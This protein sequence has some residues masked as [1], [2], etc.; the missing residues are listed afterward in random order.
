MKKFVAILCAVTMAFGLVGCEKN[1]KRKQVLLTLW[2]SEESHDLM[3][4]LADSFE[5]HYKDEA[6]IDVFVGTEPEVSLAENILDKPDEA[7]DVFHFAD[8]QI[9]SLMEKNILMP[10]TENT[11]QIIEDNGGKDTDAMQCV[12]F[13]GKIY[14]Y[15]VT[16][17][18]GY[19]MFYNS[20]YFTEDDVKSLDRMMEVAAKNGKYV[21]MDWSSGWYLYSF[22]GGAGL[23]LYMTDDNKNACNWNSTT[24]E[25]TGI[26]VAEAM[27]DIAGN[28]GFLNTDDDG[29][30][31]GVEDGS[32]IAGVNGPWNANAVSGA[33]GDS[34]RAVKLPTYTLKGQQVQ[35]SSFMG[36]KL[37]GINSKTKEAYWSTKLAEWI[38]DYDGQLERFRTTGECPANIRA[39]EAAEV[40]SSQ[41]AVAMA[42]QMPYS[43]RQNV[44]QT[45]W[46]PATS[47][48]TI[49][50]SGNSD[51]RDLQ[52]I[53]DKFVEQVEE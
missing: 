29:F 6:D 17:S 36:Y 46:T 41:V 50:A 13:D 22:F 42:G 51:N 37:V 49:L 33:W 9:V 18:N 16:A 44:A 45:F 32:I 25:D 28:P 47:L 26:D 34:Y 39:S 1:E 15:P 27:L 2:A 24:K 12:T 35:M 7:A 23:E 21:A 53:L 5:E 20:D 52:E 40:N 11:D 3:R 10:I 19:F 4:S 48:G 43:V 8:D 31:K 38:A 14:A 30:L